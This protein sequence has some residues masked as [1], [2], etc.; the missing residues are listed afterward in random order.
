MVQEIKIGVIG[1]FGHLMGKALLNGVRLAAKEI[2]EHGGVLGCSIKLIEKDDHGLPAVGKKAS[3]ELLEKEKVVGTIGFCQSAVFIESADLYQEY[4]SPLIVSVAA[5]SIIDSKFKKEKNFIFRT[6]VS[7]AI[8]ANSVIEYLEKNYTYKNIA[9]I[10]DHTV[11]GKSVYQDYAAALAGSS[12]E[13]VSHEEFSS[14]G[15]E[16]IQILKKIQ[17]KKPEII[18]LAAL[19]EDCKKIVEK[20]E[21]LG[22][23]QLVVGTWTL[24]VV[25]FFSKVSYHPLLT[26]QTFIQKGHHAKGWAFVENYLKEF[27]LDELSMEA[28]SASAQSYD[29]LKLLAAAINQ[30]KS[31]NS[32]EVL[33]ALEHLSTV[34]E[35]AIKDYK[36][37]FSQESHQ[38]LGKDSVFI[39]KIIEGELVY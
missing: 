9:I 20:M 3:L 10:N 25:D 27:D 14:V 21:S 35:G 19:S 15:E 23:G 30:A 37:P 16:M 11:Y 24:G 7:E 5:G 6:S 2:N 1:P 26:P 17:D 36:Q 22:M 13:C 38:A 33:Y 32:A 31:T 34:I 18:I 8:Y 29:A 4:Q 28:P 12:L 39:A